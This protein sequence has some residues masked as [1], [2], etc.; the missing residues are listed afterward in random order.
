MHN[1]VYFVSNLPVFICGIGTHVG[2]LFVIYYN[3]VYLSPYSKTVRERDIPVT[4]RYF[5]TYR[6]FLSNNQD[7]YDN[8][9]DALLS[10][11][12]I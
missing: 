5:E 6:F 7:I 1:D 4:L 10:T 2:N 8:L 11:F 9:Y 12:A 3:F